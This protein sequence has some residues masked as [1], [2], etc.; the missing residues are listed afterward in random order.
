MLRRGK[1]PLVPKVIRGRKDV[2]RI[3]RACH[4]EGR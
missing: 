3:F 2:K 4:K 1:L